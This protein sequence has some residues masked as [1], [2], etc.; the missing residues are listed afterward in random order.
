MANRSALCLPVQTDRLILRDFVASDCE[1]VH[2]YAS[3]PQVTQFMF[4]G[5]GEE[6]ESRAYVDAYMARML[7]SQTARP[8]T[9]FELAAV[10]RAD[11]RLIGSCEVGV[12]EEHVAAIGYVFDQDAWGQGYATE[13]A[14]AMVAAGF[15]QLAVHRIVATCDPRNAA[16]AHVLE[17]AGLRREGLLREHTRAK[18]RWWDSYLYAMLE[19]EYR[20]GRAPGQA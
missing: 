20:E 3:D 9:L 14:R 7:A 19:Q 6:Q 18:G 2:A 12:V 15:E 8:R 17:K 1:A 5:P 13:A 11:G 10:R 4:W 16:S